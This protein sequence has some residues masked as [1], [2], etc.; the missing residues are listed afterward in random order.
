MKTKMKTKMKIKENRNFYKNVLILF[1]LVVIFI[2]SLAYF[3]GFDI[4]INIESLLFYGI[5]LLSTVILFWVIFLIIDKCNNRYIIFDGEKIIRKTKD[6]ETIL[7]YYYQIL[8]TKYRNN[9]DLLYGYAD[10][11]YAEIV[12][13][14]DTKDKEAK[15]M[16]IYLSKKEY[17]QL[18]E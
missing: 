14:N 8:Y 17:K 12:Y 5:G 2:E 4:D 18:F 7:L 10:F 1:A 9:I 15:R 3:L 16:G 11:G 6:S 13:K